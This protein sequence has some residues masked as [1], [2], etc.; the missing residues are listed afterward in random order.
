MKSENDLL[1]RIYFYDCFAGQRCNTTVFA[2]AN[3][4]SDDA[5]VT[6]C[7]QWKKWKGKTI[8]QIK[9]ELG[10]DLIWIKASE[11]VG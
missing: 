1:I 8:G 6:D 10:E 5:E 3:G 7:V 2:Y 4:D 11:P 9:E